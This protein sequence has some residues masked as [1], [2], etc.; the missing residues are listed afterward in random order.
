MLDMSTARADV[1]KIY[2]AAFDRIPDSAGLYF[3]VSS[4]TSGEN[5]LES[6]AQ[7]FTNS[8]EYKIAYPS[9]M[10]TGRL[11][12]ANDLSGLRG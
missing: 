7:L 1:A 8:T 6:I 4:Y 12:K 3:W 11:T 10:T 2:I 9:F 5:T